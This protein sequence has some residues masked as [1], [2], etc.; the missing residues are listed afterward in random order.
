MKL[1][2]T[3]FQIPDLS[4]IEVPRGEWLERRLCDF[5]TALDSAVLRA[6]QIAVDAMMMPA[7]EDLPALRD[8]AEPL[9]D[10]RLLSE[11]WRFFAFEETPAALGATVEP[12]RSLAGGRVV[13]RALRIAYR[14]Y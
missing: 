9:L 14:S 1:P 5:G 8:S 10:A 3:A 12:H 2:L 6:T 13:R 11:P 4:R 7:P